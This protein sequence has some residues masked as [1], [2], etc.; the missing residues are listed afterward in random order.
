[1][2]RQ[3]DGCCPIGS[4]KVLINAETVHVGTGTHFSASPGGARFWPAETIQSGGDFDRMQHVISAF[5]LLIGFGLTACGFLVMRNPILLALLAP[6][7]KG[8]YQRMVLDRFQRN[9]LRMVGMTGS[10]FGL[11]IL[12]GV[13]SN[14]LKFKILDAVSE[15]MLALLWVSFIG[16][17]ALGIVYLIVQ[18]VRGRGREV[19]LDSFRM[20]RQGAE[21]GPITVDPAITP[22]MV[23]EVRAFTLIYCFLLALALIVALGVR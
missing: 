22:R 4:G 6:R 21:L 14:L 1:M 19:F 7:S 8:Y 13:L 11:V 23:M 3:K 18:L 17:F 12:T 20:W 15:G 10:F 2:A 5:A 9:Q 16:A